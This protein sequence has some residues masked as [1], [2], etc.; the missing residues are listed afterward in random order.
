[1]I[2]LSDGVPFMASA[3]L[4]GLVETKA[5][6]PGPDGWRVD[7]DVLTQ[8]GFATQAA[9]FLSRRLDLLAPEVRRFLAAGAVLGRT[10]DL[11]FAMELS[12]VRAEGG[13]RGKR[14]RRAAASPVAEPP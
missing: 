3:I 5:I 9:S 8:A 13:L 12:G 7:E 2:R 10:F 6:L 4:H 11:K 14:R 1:M